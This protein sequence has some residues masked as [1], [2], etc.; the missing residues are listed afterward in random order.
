MRIMV[1]F[2]T[3]PEAIK[4]CPLVNEL[5]RRPAI[6]T[7]VCVTGQ[8]KEMLHQ[9]LEA[10]A[11]YFTPRLKE[12]ADKLSKSPIRSKNKEDAGELLPLLKDLYLTLQQ[13]IHLTQAIAKEADVKTYL[14]AKQSFTC[15]P[16]EVKAI[17]DRPKKKSISKNVKSR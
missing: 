5:K 4:M 11:G 17:Y 7:I 9:R 15:P 12:M 16:M 10:S 6:E 8:H 14:N 13:K 2:G 3:R 1:I